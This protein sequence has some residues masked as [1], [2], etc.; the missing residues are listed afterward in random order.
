MTDSISEKGTSQDERMPA[1]LK[2]GYINAD[3]RL[4]S[5]FLAMA[6][7]YAPVIRFFNLADEPYGDWEPFFTSDE[8]FIIA[9]ILATDLAR[10]ESEFFLF[11]RQF[12]NTSA[13]FGSG[14]DLNTIP[15]YAL[16]RQIDFWRNKLILTESPEG[17]SLEEHITGVI[18]KKLGR[19]LEALE[20]YL[21]QYNE[22]VSEEI[23]KD[24]NHVWFDRHEE[25]GPLSPVPSPTDDRDFLKSNF[26]SFYNAV[27]FLKNSAETI[28]PHSLQ[29][30]THNP[31]AGLYIAFIK[32]LQRIQTK[33]NGFTEAHLNFYYNDILKIRRRKAV[34]DSTYLVF[35]PI[36][37]RDI[38]IEKGTEF[39]AGSDEEYRDILFTADND[40]LVNNAQ[41]AS[42]C[43]LYLERDELSSPEKELDFISGAR[44]NQIPVLKEVGMEG[45]EELKAWPVFG[46]PKRGTGSGSF[47]DAL[48]GFAVAS[49]VLFLKEG[50]RTITFTFTMESTDRE[51]GSRLHSFLEELKNILNT[52][53]E[54]AFIKAF[55]NM[56]T[57]SLTAKHGWLKVDEYLP[58]SQVIDKEC[59]ED[60]LKIQIRLL[61]DAGPIVS[62]SPEV[63]GEGYDTGVPLARFI[64]NPGAYLYP[65]S[66][67]RNIAIGQLEIEVD[68]KGARDM[69][70]Y[71]NLGQLDPGSP[72]YPFG[73][74]PAM[75]SYCIIGNHETAMKRVTR[76]ELSIE[77]GDLPSDR[78]GFKEYYGAYGMPFD[79]S[80]F[81]ARVSLLK[82]G[83]WVPREESDQPVVKLFTS[84]AEEGREEGTYRIRKK[85]LLS[86]DDVV[87]FFKPL[88][89]AHLIHGFGYSA[90]ARDGFFRL[91]L[92]G[93][94][95]AFG[96]KD[97]PFILTEVLT[98]NTR[99]KKARLLKPLPNMPYTPLVNALSINYSAVSTISMEHVTSSGEAHLQ[100]KV[101]HIQ[102]FG[103]EHLSPAIHKNISL[104]PPYDRAGNLFIGLSAETFSGLITLFFH[105]REDSAPETYGDPSQVMWFYLSS[106]QWKILEKSRV[107]SDTTNGFLSPG[108]VTLKIPKDINRENTVMPGNLFWLRA[109]RK[110]HPEAPCSVYSVH[111]QALKVSR[112]QGENAL[113]YPKQGLPA[114]SIKEP[115]ISIPGIG[116]ITQIVDSSGGGPPE[117]SEE[118]RIRVSERLRHKN[119]A[120]ASWDYQ[121]LILERFPDIFKVKCFANMVAEQDPEKRIRPGHILIV[122]IPRLREQ[123]PE[124]MKPMV[125]G[126]LL[127]EIKEFIGNIASPF[128]AIT[129][130]NPAY[131]RIQVRCTV[132]F[133][134]RDGGGYY[135]NILNRA[136]SDHLSPWHTNG[137][138]TQFGWSIRAYDIISYI[139]DLDYVDFVTNFSM[140]HIAEYGKDHFRMF[141]T[142]REQ[143]DEKGIATI[144]PLYPWSVAIPVRHHFIETTDRS[145]RIAP[146]ITGIDELEIGSTFII[147]G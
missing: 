81:T 114:G 141:D 71:N 86:C 122:V 53:I 120:A 104:I 20:N 144:R 58:L 31:A 52:S 50:E 13:F 100:D 126:L 78:G 23:K 45:G 134:K 115:R 98:A 108:I 15:A 6:A 57:I 88:D 61:P 1:A 84:D 8:A 91:S 93:S 17:R 36:G 124:N 9:L 41:V 99:L 145:E 7:E 76:F 102:P 2:E 55:R 35:H 107:I 106:N 130:R 4:F 11:L 109:S 79:N 142:V 96:H 137:Y 118:L 128:A 146:E 89:T 51:N 32:L 73:P 5:D 24:F 56:F 19:E 112:Q 125:P 82:D 95:Y 10:K 67:L 72:F 97:Y 143:T 16:A 77:W 40:L 46:A 90:Q 74:Q 21:K 65:Y 80:G 117:N 39:R 14:Y 25:E 43:T 138:G 127:R 60:H 129:V 30:G 63:H 12:D 37:G 38:F 136:I 48:F 54:D 133:K 66:L 131:E 18:E 64:I 47:K 27:L 132:K 33:I 75:G 62:Y 68:V 105:M 113:S 29:S 135:I 87:K 116:K 85:R 3:E 42:L 26:C 101:F 49:P 69:L 110:N 34:P 111:A 119:R 44:V 123:F 140:L 83:K 92:A 28:L 139:R 103:L 22:Q 70:V 147:Q 94:D 121:R 59:G